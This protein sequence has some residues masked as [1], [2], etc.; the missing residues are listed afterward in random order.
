MTQ[1][2]ALQSCNSKGGSLVSIESAYQQARVLKL[3]KGATFD[4][5]W[6]GLNE[7]EVEGYWEWTDGSTYSY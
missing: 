2:Q 7:I 1:P 4:V 5:Y 3:L 6:L